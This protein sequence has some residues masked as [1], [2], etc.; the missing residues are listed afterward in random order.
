VN[1]SKTINA[2]QRRTRCR[3]SVRTISQ[4]YFASEAP[5]HFAHEAVLFFIM[6][7]TAAL[8]ILNASMAILALIRI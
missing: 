8:P 1:R 5:E 6:M 4:G 3:S 7:M 2:K